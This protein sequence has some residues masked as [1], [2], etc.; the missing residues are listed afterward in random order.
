MPSSR[1]ERDERWARGTAAY[2]SQ[3]R[4][5]EDEV[6]DRLAATVG[7][8]MA[9][10]AILAAGGVWADDGVLSLRERSLV[11]VTALVT[12]GGVDARLRGHVRWALDHGVSPEELEAAIALLAVYVGYPKTSVAM[13]VVRE[14]L[15]G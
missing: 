13:E 2:A 10:E 1:P 8:R 3:F 15:A 6:F 12:Q 7:E 11:V 5:G 14:V 4:I 9:T